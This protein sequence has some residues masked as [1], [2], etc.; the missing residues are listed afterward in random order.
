[1]FGGAFPNAQPHEIIPLTS[2]TYC[3]LCLSE[4]SDF[5]LQLHDPVAFMF[6]FLYSGC[7]GWG[8]S[9]GSFAYAYLLPSAANASSEQLLTSYNDRCSILFLT[10]LCS[11]QE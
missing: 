4:C 1:M 7:Q 8:S 11:V 6:R 10:T 3:E 2:A 5:Q 9:S